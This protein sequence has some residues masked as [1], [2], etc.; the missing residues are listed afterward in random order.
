[1]E[2]LPD[3]A[4]AQTRGAHA[5]RQGQARGGGITGAENPEGE[6]GQFSWAVGWEPL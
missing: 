1:M 3:V 5:R 2:W 6:T 4:L